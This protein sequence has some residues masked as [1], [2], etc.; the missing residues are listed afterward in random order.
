MPAGLILNGST[1][2]ITGTPTTAGTANFTVQAQDS[3][4]TPQTASKA[5]ALTINP[6]T[7]TISTASPLPAGTV[8]TA[9]SQTV[10]AT[11]GTAP[12]A[13]SITVGALPAGLTLNGS[14][15]AIT[16]TPTTSGTANF[17]VQA[18]DSAGTPQT[19]SK[20]FAL[21]INPATLT[22][23]T[24]SPLTAGTVGTAYSQTVAADRRYGALCVV[25]HGG[26]VAGWSHSEW[27]DWRDYGNTD[28]GGNGELYCAG[29]GLGRHATDCIEGVC[30]DDQSGDADD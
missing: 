3:A 4:G 7:L 14:T 8:G 21:T 29:A 24:A 11:G 5:F 10:A 6:A 15:G 30:A 2:A 25:D 28:D 18:Q 23:S 27:L 13:W 19:A 1:G 12:Y 17:T 9:Y 20:A 16:G 26:G 22:I